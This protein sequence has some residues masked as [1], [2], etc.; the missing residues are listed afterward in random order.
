[1]PVHCRDNSRFLGGRC[2]FNLA[3]YMRTQVWSSGG[4]TQSAAIAALICKGELRPDISVIVDTEREVQQTWDYHDSVIV[5]AL[6]QVGVT[7]H[8]VPKSKYATVDLYGGKDGDALLIPAFTNKNG[9]Q[10]KLPTYCS[11]E[12]KSRVVQRFCRDMMP[13]AEAFTL[14]LGISRDEFNRMRGE[15]GEGKWTYWH[16]LIAKLM[17]RHD[18]VSLV[19]SMG[20]PPP[21]RSRCFMCPNQGPAEWADLDKNHP[22]D[23]AKARAFEAEIQVKDPN[24]YL[25][26]AL[27]EDGDCMS[28]FCFT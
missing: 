6:A 21:P 17:N 24:V 27:A 9:K 12:W 5:P 28:G 23:A 14:W 4:G 18:C 3:V 2:R 16:P 11:N 25:R 8:R 1:M 13:E 26:N 15:G 7:L 20:W 10:G 22:A 19:K